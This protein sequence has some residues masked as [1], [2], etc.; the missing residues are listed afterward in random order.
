MNELMNVS[1]GHVGLV[2]WLIWILIGVFEALV[3]GRAG[4]SPL[5]FNII[6]G[7]VAS[8][9]GGYLS[10]CFL[11]DTPMQLFLISLLGA[12]FFGAVALWITGALINHFRKDM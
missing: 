6:I 7:V 11:G 2:V 4:R 12:I 8:C 10:T 9:L 3:A 1:A 5:A